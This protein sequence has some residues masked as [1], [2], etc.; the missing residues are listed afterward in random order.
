MLAERFDAARDHS[1]REG[2]VAPGWGSAHE[3]QAVAVQLRGLVHGAAVVLERPAALGLGLGAEEAPATQAG[4]PQP[5]VGD[6]LCRAGNAELGDALAPGSD[7]ADPVASAAL[8]ELSQRP[9]ADR[10]L[11]EAQ[12]LQRQR[13]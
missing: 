7:R 10:Y 5:R 2:Q 12:P 1:P 13:S 4:D 3:N 9:L 6:E 8:D 11:V